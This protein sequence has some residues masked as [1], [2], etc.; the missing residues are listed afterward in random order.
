MSHINRLIGEF[1]RRELEMREYV[2]LAPGVAGSSVRTRISG[3]VHTFNVVPDDFSGWGIFRPEN[4]ITAALVE[5][6]GRAQVDS[7]L[8]LLPRIALRLIA[9]LGDNASWLASPANGGEIER[10]VEW[11]KGAIVHLVEEGERFDMICARF[12]LV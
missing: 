8:E 4:A 7:Y 12:V 3:L 1:A 10:K 9:P 2:F 11:E 5:P 6:A